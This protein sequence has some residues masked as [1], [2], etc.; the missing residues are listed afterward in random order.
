MATKK[1]PS[2]PEQIAQKTVAKPVAEKQITTVSAEEIRKDWESAQ[3]KIRETHKEQVARIYAELS[4]PFPQEVERVLN[5]GGASLIYIPVSEV[6]NRLNRV[7]GVTGWSCEI[8]KCDRD[9][10][11]PEFIV[12]HVRLIINSEY[13]DFAITKDGFGGQKI[14]RTRSGDIVDL[15]DEFKG[16]VSDALKKAAQQLGV[17]L[18]LSRTEDAMMIEAQNELSPEAK[19]VQDLYQTFSGLRAQMDDKGVEAIRAYWKTWS[20]GRPVPK[21]NDFTAEELE[22]LITEATRILVSGEYV[23]NSE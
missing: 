6:I 13:P 5:K 3:V 19:K 17:G 1:A 16:A 8:I 23:G 21:P 11:D 4:E 14:K 20:N 18:Y 22:A 15:G 9:S 7:F 2:E 10:L 12:A